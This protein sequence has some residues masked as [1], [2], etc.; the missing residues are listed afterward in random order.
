MTGE[1]VQEKLLPGLDRGVPCFISLGEVKNT[2]PS[3][4]GVGTRGLIQ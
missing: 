2:A 4:G 3:K 1:E